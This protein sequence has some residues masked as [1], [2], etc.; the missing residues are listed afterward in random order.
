MSPR[1]SVQEI[2]LVADL[3]LSHFYSYTTFCIAAALAE[4]RIRSENT[5]GAAVEGFNRRGVMQGIFHPST[6]ILC[7]IFL[8][9]K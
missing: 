5:S 1:R 2:P 9:N 4:H 8:L 7:L 3:A 6:L